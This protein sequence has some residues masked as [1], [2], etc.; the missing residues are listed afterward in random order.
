MD[1]FVF[2]FFL[3]KSLIFRYFL[4]FHVRFEDYSLVITFIP[5]SI[6]SMK[7]V[8]FVEWPFLLK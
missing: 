8:W 5:I 7:L 2:F 4:I 1:N 3:W 6:G